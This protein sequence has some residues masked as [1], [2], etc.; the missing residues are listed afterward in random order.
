VVL[1]RVEIFFSF[2]TKSVRAGLAGAS[3]KQFSMEE[4]V[5]QAAAATESCGTLLQQAERAVKDLQEE[6]IGFQQQLVVAKQAQLDSRAEFNNLTLGI[7]TGVLSRDDT[8][9]YDAAKQHVDLVTEFCFMAERAC[10]ETRLQLHTARHKM[11]Q[12]ILAD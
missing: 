12:A 6:L 1:S 2:S 7:E 9:A 10:D 11:Q 4:V 5:D 3:S 8:D